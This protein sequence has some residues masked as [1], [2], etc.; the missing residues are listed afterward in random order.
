MGR[1]PMNTGLLYMA[2]PRYRGAGEFI[3]EI[4]LDRIPRIQD[5]SVKGYTQKAPGPGLAIT[6]RL[7]AYETV[8][9]GY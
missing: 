8:H 7:I 5:V 6:M 9:Q 1:K 4:S 2:F 3:L